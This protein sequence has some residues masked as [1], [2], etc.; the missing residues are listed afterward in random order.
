MNRKQSGIHVPARISTGNDTPTRSLSI[1]RKGSINVPSRTGSSGR[2]PE[3]ASGSPSTTVNKRTVPRR[4]S[5]LVGGSLIDVTSD[6]KNTG[7]SESVS[8]DILHAKSHS[9]NLNE[10]PSD[11]T[12]RS[13]ANF[14]NNQDS[15]SYGDVNR[16]S[17]QESTKS[18]RILPESILSSHGSIAEH[19]FSKREAEHKAEI[20]N[21]LD[22][23]NIEASKQAPNNKVAL[24]KFYAAY[25]LA[26]KDNDLILQSKAL[27]NVSCILRR[28]GNV[29]NALAVMKLSWKKTSTYI[30][31]NCLRGVS[32]WLRLVVDIVENEFDDEHS[33]ALNA[34]DSDRNFNDD[35]FAKGP[36][37]V[38]WFMQLLNNMGNCHFSAGNIENAVKYYSLCMDLATNVLE[39]YPLPADYT[40]VVGEEITSRGLSGQNKTLNRSTS[41]RVS[42][43]DNERISRSENPK[44][45][46]GRPELS[47]LHKETVLSL[48]RSK[49]L[50]GI[51]YQSL[52]L[53]ELALEYQKDALGNI[54]SYI[55]GR[56]I[57]ILDITKTQTNSTRDFI[58]TEACIKSNLGSAYYVK[59]DIPLAWQF[60]ENSKAIYKSIGFED[61]VVIQSINIGSL[62]SATAKLLNSAQ[63]IKTIESY[64][65]D[66][67]ED[68]KASFIESISNLWN[69]P[70]F[71]S[72]L[73]RLKNGSS[74]KVLSPDNTAYMY[75][76]QMID[77]SIC[78][79]FEQEEYLRKA[80]SY[81]SLSALWM[82]VAN[83]YFQLQ[84]P[85]L[86]LYFLGLIV[87]EAESSKIA[88]S[89]AS[90]EVLYKLKENITIDDIKH[91]I[92]KSHLLD[93]S[94]KPYLY[95]LI[96]QGFFLLSHFSTDDSLVFNIKGK[97]H[98][99]TIKDF[100]TGFDVL[101]PN[102]IN[103]LLKVLDFKNSDVSNIKGSNINLIFTEAQNKFE[104]HF[105]R[106]LILNDKFIK[107]FKDFDI[108]KQISSSMISVQA[109]YTL[110]KSPPGSSIENII[111][112]LA[113]AYAP[114][115]VGVQEHKPNSS[116]DVNSSKGLQRQMNVFTIDT[117]TLRSP[118]NS[119]T[120]KSPYTGYTDYFNIL[121][122]EDNN[123]FGK[124]DTILMDPTT[125]IINNESESRNAIHAL[126]LTGADLL[127]FSADLIYFLIYKLNIK[128]D[129]EE[130]K[131]YFP[132]Y[133]TQ[134]NN[135]LKAAKLRINQ[136]LGLCPDCESDI[137]NGFEKYALTLE[138][139][140][141]GNGD[142]KRL[143]TK[144]SRS[145]LSY[146]DK[147]KAPLSRVASR[148]ESEKTEIEFGIDEAN[149]SSK[150]LA[151]Q[152]DNKISGSPSSLGFAD[153]EAKFDVASICSD[154]CSI[155]SEKNA[156]GT[157]VMRK[158][159]REGVIEFTFPVM[160]DD[161]SR[162]IFYGPEEIAAKS[163]VSSEFVRESSVLNQQDS[164]SFNIIST[165]NHP[166][167]NG[168]HVHGIRSSTSNLSEFVSSANLETATYVAESKLHRNHSVKL[169]RTHSYAVR[170]K[171]PS[172][173]FPCNHYS[174]SAISKVLNSTI[175]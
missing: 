31:F 98:D 118:I 131:K 9:Y 144:K 116:T 111:S 119:P 78:T 49:T 122:L 127:L 66:M 30:E 170:T 43:K 97:N 63:W 165:N 32:V 161:Y 84:N 72:Q 52:G 102:S 174:S 56:N 113:K 48:S 37:L 35:D 152:F 18:T 1:K 164:S 50:L 75:G 96:A 61:S 159:R 173:N 71:I 62:Y 167:S 81:K 6:S 101:L 26:L 3:W 135:L 41:V 166:V 93:D 117:P 7:S 108:Y 60:H 150:S 175:A 53:D 109:K 137:V 77:K 168:F 24:D 44:K 169:Q 153:V 136:S 163:T 155:R 14:A 129:S 19:I 156:N 20:E 92:F 15:G 39:E 90:D 91:D 17:V 103:K 58:E 38:V 73:K 65:E 121:N 104:S 34:R 54:L 158:K 46:K 59:G 25:G 110:L 45:G 69:P 133:A 86:G 57:P 120:L 55:N 40:T 76:I 125:G 10:S 74:A 147:N 114:L 112:L 64:N 132:S 139:K 148:N 107:N 23:G 105:D 106:R 145:K 140:Y 36:P 95:Y 141:G 13:L 11:F 5:N 12:T 33:L 171:K 87:N 115:L 94:A 21:L 99:S 172:M 88:E 51:C 126:N 134:L 160:K 149:V 85:Y 124:L 68:K 28:N 70:V 142:L 79:L 151:I 138:K 82:N 80:K 8:S 83:A 157:P 22:E 16:Y 128:E 162:R 4:S 2:L 130:F 154:K 100:G 42:L 146:S 67:S 29:Q 89:L 27:S 143:G 47:Y 123:I